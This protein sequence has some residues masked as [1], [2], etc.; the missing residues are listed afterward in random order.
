MLQTKQD[1]GYQYIRVQEIGH[2]GWG[3]HAASSRTSERGVR[4][5][6]MRPRTA[7]T[8][9][10]LFVSALTTVMPDGNGAGRARAAITATPAAYEV[11]P[12]SAFVPVQP[13]TDARSESGGVLT[14]ASGGTCTF[15]A[16]L[17]LPAG[18]TIGSVTLVGIDAA[19]IASMIA[20]V[21]RIDRFE[22]SGLNP[23][24]IVAV[25]SSGTDPAVRTFTSS[26]VTGGLVDPLNYYYV[27]S[28]SVAPGTQL[29]GVRVG[30]DPPVSPPATKRVG[31]PGI[32]FIPRNSVSDQKSS[33]FGILTSDASGTVRFVAPVRLPKGA[34]VQRFAL[35]AR[36]FST[37]DLTARLVRVP[38]ASTTGTVMATVGSAGSDE[39]VREFSTSTISGA[40]IDPVN[41]VYYA[42]ILLAST[43][44]AYGVTID[45]TGGVEAG[46][47]S[48][49]AV[50]LLACGPTSTSADHA[51]PSGDALTGSSSFSCDAR[52]PD[53]AVLGALRLSARDG[54]STSN[55]VVSVMRLDA[56]GAA[57]EQLVGQV[58]SSGSSA[59]LAQYTQSASLTEPIDNGR[60]FYSLRVQQGAG[61]DSVA[62]RVEFA[63]APCVDG[64]DDGFVTCGA[65]ALQ[66]GQTCGDCR[67]SDRNVYPGA[68]QICDGVNDDCSDPSWPAVPSSESDGDGDGVAACAGDCNDANS[69]VHPGATEVCN[70]I[71]DDCD[72][73]MD[74]GYDADGDGL[75]VCVD[76]CPAT[77]NA[78]QSDRDDDGL[79]DACET[80]S[81]L[82]D[83][84][85]SGR[86]DGFDLI[87]MARAWGAAS[88]EATYDASVDLDGSGQVDGTD[89][90][91]L[92]APFGATVSS[93]LVP[94]QSL[95]A[96]A[97]DAVSV[98][99]SWVD[100]TGGG[101]I[102]FRIDR[103]DGASG[104]F[105]T[106]RSV[107]VGTNAIDDSGLMPLV[108]YTYRV[109]AYNAA[110]SSAY[111]NLAAVNTPS[112][113]PRPPS[114]LTATGASSSQI[115]LHWVDQ[116]SDEEGFAIE[117]AP[118]GTAAFAEIAR[119]GA[120]VVDYADSGLPSAMDFDYRVRAYN[121]FGYSG[122]SNVDRG[123]T[124]LAP[125]TAP[126]GLL[127][128]AASTTQIHLVW[129]DNSTIETGFTVERAPGGTTS[130]AVIAASLPPNT[131]SY[132]DSG[133]TSGQSYAYR[134]KA[135]N[136]A[137]PSSYSNTSTATA[138]PQPPSA[139]SGLTATAQTPSSIRLNWTDNS[140]NEDGF[141]IERSTGGGAYAPVG[142][143]GANVGT[144]TSSSLSPMMTYSFRVRAFNS[145]GNSSYTTPASATT[146]VSFMSNVYPLL[147]NSTASGGAGCISCHASTVRNDPVDAT[148]TNGL[149]FNFNNVTSVYHEVTNDDGSEARSRVNVSSPDSSRLL[150][151]P[152]N[153]A[154]ESHTLVF[155][156]SDSRYQLLRKWISEGA[157]NN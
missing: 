35:H 59:T 143:V 131:T 94:P 149:S 141:S 87:R 102:G 132:D 39:A 45:Y 6:T 133:L 22:F 120:G 62:A 125:P 113:T 124:Q 21:T 43:V 78:S 61:I 82:A 77:L 107:P 14:C 48:P 70:G 20:R 150:Q 136:A 4:E 8:G 29:Y 7:R 58:S 9:L 28:V 96:A 23:H 41:N 137:G 148:H 40:T 44:E 111:S 117:R 73:S 106:V 130:F 103:K 126:S 100:A 88:P 127:A 25:I 157:Q 52:F 60:Y 151:Y 155:S 5:A 128:S 51:A 90:T 12:G 2:T 83:V 115:Q 91:L 92:A 134:V 75:G 118:G 17:A 152:T 72:G 66:A 154:G 33:F 38:V 147:H 46:L 32:T 15:V 89:L 142:S 104:A 140:S 37:V 105:H 53:G 47:N 95:Q 156:T 109:R 68:T 26:S 56:T 71:D 112:G 27:V 36:D 50:A 55:A 1:S 54:A 18:A 57:A 121:A 153:R 19:S 64:D 122:Y 63:L 116:S 138:T 24:S 67:D 79:G 76:N 30:Y 49:Q 101:A 80:G 97:I 74:E 145:G 13:S 85:H 11:I 84:D 99:V 110:A 31:I 114:D 146:L 93:Y 16:P 108:E 144:F 3:G 123:T 139:P 98:R 86:V 81:V 34:V 119:V 65:C 69:A 129:T 42:E 135:F 10:I